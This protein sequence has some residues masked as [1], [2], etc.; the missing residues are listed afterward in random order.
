MYLN[1]VTQLA[2]LSVDV[3]LLRLRL[4][5]RTLEL[6]QKWLPTRKPENSV[7][8][9]CIARRNQLGAHDPEMFPYQVDGITFDL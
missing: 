9:A 8:V 7:W 4:L 2:Q 6:N 1:L 3:F 5:T